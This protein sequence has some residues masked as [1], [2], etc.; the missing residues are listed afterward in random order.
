[1]VPCSDGLYG[2]IEVKVPTAPLENQPYSNRAPGYKEEQVKESVRS[3]STRLQLLRKVCYNTKQVGTS[4]T[5]R[6]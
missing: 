4:I 1:M 3:K 2:W 6:N 5:H